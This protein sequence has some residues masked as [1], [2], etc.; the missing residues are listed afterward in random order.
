MTFNSFKTKKYF[1]HKNPILDDLKSFLVYKFTCASCC[2]SYIGGTCLHFKT[3]I[4]ERIKKDNKSDISKH[5]YSTAIC[6][7]SCISL[8]FKRID[9]F[10]SKFHLQIKKVDWKNIDWKKLNLN[11][12]QNH[13]SLT[14][15]L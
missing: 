5:L 3:K 14:R 11:T 1:S 12:K 8:S 9:K 6:F 7:D 2:S 4:D 10:N 15:S 13:L